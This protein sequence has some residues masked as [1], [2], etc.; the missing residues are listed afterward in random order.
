MR[1][2]PETLESDLIESTEMVV[3]LQDIVESQAARIAEL[4][5]QLVAMTKDRDMWKGEC[6]DGTVTKQLATLRRKIDEAPVVA[7]WYP[8]AGKAIAAG[9]LYWDDRK[10]MM[11]AGTKLI[12]KE[13]LQ[14]D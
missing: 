11:E 4:E 3:K 8:K 1:L 2:F 7:W 9:R 14:N 10:E 5:S 6:L 13:D 12:S